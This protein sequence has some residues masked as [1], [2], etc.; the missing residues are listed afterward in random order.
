MRTCAPENV[1]ALHLARGRTVDRVR[2]GD[3]EGV[4]REVDDAAPDLF[5]GVERDLHGPV[6]EVGVRVQVRD[7]GDDLRDAGLVVG[8]EERRAVGRDQ[9]VAGVVL[10]LGRLV[11]ADHLA[12]SP[13]TI[14]PPS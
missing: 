7:C 13:S 12:E 4:D 11:R 2:R 6:R 9:L 10:E 8:A 3:A 5:V 14:S 1:L